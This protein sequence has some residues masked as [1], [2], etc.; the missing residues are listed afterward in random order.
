LIQKRFFQFVTNYRLL[1]VNI[2]CGFNVTLT[3]VFLVF[4]VLKL[5]DG[6]QDARQ[7]FAERS[8]TGRRKTERKPEKTGIK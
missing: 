8:G 7:A 4:E 3:V 6:T 1:Q 2:I 5:F